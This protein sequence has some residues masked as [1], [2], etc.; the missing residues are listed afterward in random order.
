MDSDVILKVEKLSLDFRLRTE[1]LHAVR[2]VSLR[3]AERPHTLPRRRKRIGQERH[4]AHH[5]PH[6]RQECDDH[7]GS[8]PP[9]QP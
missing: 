3:A 5:P 7:L 1:I 2:D 8:H 4:R 6:P 9:R